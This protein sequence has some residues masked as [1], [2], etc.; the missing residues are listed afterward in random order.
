MDK[1]K[2][3]NVTST[4]T[5]IKWGFGLGCGCLLFVVAVVL[6]VFGFIGGCSMWVASDYEGTQNEV[7]SSK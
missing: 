3:K 4:G 5:P 1:I 6:C 7:R 2:Q